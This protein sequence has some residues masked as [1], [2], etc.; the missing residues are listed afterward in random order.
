MSSGPSNLSCT[1]PSHPSAVLWP[2]ESINSRDLHDDCTHPLFPPINPS[3]L[4]PSQQSSPPFQPHLRETVPQ[5]DHSQG[6]ASQTDI[7]T[8]DIEKSVVV[9]DGPEV[10]NM[11][12]DNIE[13]SPLGPNSQDLHDDCAHPLSSPSLQP[14]PV[15]H[16]DHSQGI[17]SQ[18]KIVSDDIEKST[19]AG[20]GLELNRMD[21]DNIEKSAVA[22]HWF[23]EDGNME[24]NNIFKMSVQ[25]ILTRNPITPVEEPPPEVQWLEDLVYYRYGFF[26]DEAPYESPEGIKV[27]IKD[28]TSVCRSVGGQHLDL[29]S[30]KNLPPIKD[31]VN[32]LANTKRP[33]TE[34][35][36]KYWDLSEANE[37]F[38]SMQ[39]SHFRIEVKQFDAEAL[40]F[41]HPRGLEPSK[42]P[43]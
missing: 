8:D 38:L 11:D 16:S 30:K 29:S 21:I 13:K 34:V 7:V 14:L 32:I 35:P 22:G 10:N 18:T 1:H 23:E 33:F 40:C 42:C 41:L 15:P 24:T 43:P 9:E 12:V 19:V 37:G 39:E 28:S 5:S 31:F 25:D 3:A 26:L 20:D 27:F 6:V 4:P 36:S 17:A 2:R